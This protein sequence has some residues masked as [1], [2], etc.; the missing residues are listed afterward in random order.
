MCSMMALMM[1]IQLFM[2]MMISWMTLWAK[3]SERF[4]MIH[5]T[6][7]TAAFSVMMRMGY[8]I[9]STKIGVPLMLETMPGIHL[10]QVTPAALPHGD[11]NNN[12]TPNLIEFALGQDTLPYLQPENMSLDVPIAREALEEEYEVKVWFSEDLINW[13]S[14]PSELTNGSSL[15]S[16]RENNEENTI[17]Q[18]SFDSTLQRLFWRI[19]VS[20]P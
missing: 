7:L 6:D 15:D 19:S 17:L 13:K 11:H 2:W 9:L 10:W 20:E 4:S 14:N 3:R 16:E 12:G 1:K 8:F 18:F 5:H